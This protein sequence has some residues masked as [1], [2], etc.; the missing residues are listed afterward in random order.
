[1][2]HFSIFKTMALVIA[3]SVSLV[4][5]CTKEQ[6]SLSIDDISG[7]AKIIGSYFYDAG[8][9]YV[10]GKYVQL[11]K[12]A[13]NVTIFA[14]I[15]NA[16]LSPN[17]ES[18]GYTTYSTVT[19]D[20]GKFEFVL[21]A[22]NKGVS[23]SISPKPF[24]G[25]HTIVVGTNNGKPKF[26]EQNVVY[27]ATETTVTLK[28][29]DIQ[30]VDSKM[31]V[32]STQDLENGF[33]YHSTFIV[34]VGEATYR[35]VYI[36]SSE[37][38]EKAYEEASGVEVLTHIKQDG[39]TYTYAATTNSSGEAKF[40]IPSKEAR[41]STS[42]SIEVAPY[43]KNNF[44][45]Y[46]LENG[47]INQYRISSGAYTMFSGSSFIQATSATVEFSDIASAPAQVLKVRMVFDPFEGEETYNYS[48]TD[49][50]NI[51]F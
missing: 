14:K 25:T 44:V 17:G 45:Y 9:D 35:K 49:W 24:Q 5:A 6:T 12:P 51:S 20:D 19:D 10:G 16:S 47:S 23:V 38:I 32:S 4:S 15:S 21:P 41:W 3:V 26:E 8:Q 43:L 28:A 46:K 22:T 11:I 13:A 31:A 34:K 33:P 39:V 37:Q 7:R 29:N 18:T 30:F 40:I 42:V 50:R 1:M 36:S 27:S 2:K 48:Y